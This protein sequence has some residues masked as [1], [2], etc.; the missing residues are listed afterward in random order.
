MTF[1]SITLGLVSKSMLNNAQLIF[2]AHAVFAVVVDVDND[3]DVEIE[4][5]VEVEVLASK[6]SIFV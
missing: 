2:L 1:F 6:I 3:V 5:G 4:D